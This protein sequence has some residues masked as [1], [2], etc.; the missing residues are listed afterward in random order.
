MYVGK[1]RCKKRGNI[2]YNV[3][4][5]VGKNSRVQSHVTNL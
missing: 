5:V 4:R 3:T 1:Y 2:F